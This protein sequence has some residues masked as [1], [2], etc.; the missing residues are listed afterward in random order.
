MNEARRVAHAAEGAHRQQAAARAAAERSAP[1]AVRVRFLEL[2]AGDG[3]AIPHWPRER[4]FV[5]GANGGGFWRVRRALACA[6][7]ASNGC[8][9]SAPIAARSCASTLASRPDADVSR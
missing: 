4:L 2:R 9:H 5:A 3:G 1:A 7:S 8:V 6:C